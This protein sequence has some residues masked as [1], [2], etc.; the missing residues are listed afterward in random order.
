MHVNIF[1]VDYR[2]GDLMRSVDDCSEDEVS[3]FGVIAFVSIIASIYDSA[4]SIFL[5]TLFMTLIFSRLS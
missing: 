4:V 1:S 2:S 5:L 3:L